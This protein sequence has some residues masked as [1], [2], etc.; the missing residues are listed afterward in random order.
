MSPPYSYQVGVLHSTP[1]HS[2]RLVVSGILSGKGHFWHT[3]CNADTG[4]EDGFTMVDA[5]VAF[6]SRNNRW[7][8]AVTGE[9]L[10]DEKYL[11]GSFTVAALHVSSGYLNP[12]RRL[13]VNLRYAFD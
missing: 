10:S 12:P 6:E 9:N 4:S 5:S 13:G 3:T 11:I 1:V 2:G 7:R 8:I